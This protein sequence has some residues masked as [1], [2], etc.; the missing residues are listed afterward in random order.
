M[1]TN[2]KEGGIC[3]CTV[4]VHV[5]VLLLIHHIPDSSPGRLLLVPSAAVSGTS[6]PS[7]GDCA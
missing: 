7:K 1:H 5:S 6:A 3:L 4:Y 2:V